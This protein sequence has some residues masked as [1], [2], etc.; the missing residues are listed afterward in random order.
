MHRNVF[1]PQTH[2]YHI[3]P[4][5]PPPPPISLALPSLSPAPPPSPSYIN[6]HYIIGTLNILVP[7]S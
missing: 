4:L 2:I 7:M 3:Y 1:V 5:S 6:R